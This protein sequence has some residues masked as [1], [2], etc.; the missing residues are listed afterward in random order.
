MSKEIKIYGEIGTKDANAQQFTSD[1]KIAEQS[2]AKSVIIRLHSVGGSV[3]DGNVI[4]NAMILSPLHIKIIIDGLAASMASL[5]LIAADEVEICENALIMIHRPTGGGGG[6]ADTIESIVKPLRDIESVMIQSFATKTGIPTDDVKNKWFDGEDHWLNADEAV[7]Y[8]LADRKIA[9]VAKGV[10]AKITAKLD[11]DSI[12]KRFASSLNIK[13]EY[14][15][16]KE[17]IEIFDLKGVTAESSDEEVMQKLI[18]KFDALEKQVNESTETQVNALL[19]TAEKEFKISATQRNTYF[20]IGKT[21]GVAALNAVLGDIKPIPSIYSM[22]RD[23][24]K[25]NTEN[26]KGMPKA[27]ADWKLDDYR[28]NAPHELRNNPKL[29]KAL[30]KQEYGEQE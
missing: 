22:I 13:N 24:D 28:K 12:Y 1:L 4:F 2:G 5:F 11:T 23:K 16:K 21:A 3:I 15:M 17:L 30:V 6:N 25:N 19:D 9:A 20:T 10:T 18:E 7:Q 27:K 26:D 29:Y 14:N 8:H